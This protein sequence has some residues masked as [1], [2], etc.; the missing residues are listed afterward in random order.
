MLLSPHISSVSMCPFDCWAIIISFSGMKEK[1]RMIFEAATAHCCFSPRPSSSRLKRPSSSNHQFEVRDLDILFC[2]TASVTE[3]P[4][5]RLP[6]LSHNQV[7]ITQ[8]EYLL[9]YQKSYYLL[10]YLFTI[11]QLLVLAIHPQDQLQHQDGWI[12]LQHYVSCLLELA[13]PPECKYHRWPKSINIEN[14]KQKS[15]QLG[16]AKSELNTHIQSLY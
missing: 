9:T 11:L 5:P 14:N 8:S 3:E 7:P 15:K 10:T 6:T 2:T 1:F 4:D 16:F 13:L 12:S